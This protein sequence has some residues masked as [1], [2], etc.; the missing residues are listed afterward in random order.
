M[1]HYVKKMNNVVYMFDCVRLYVVSVYS[2][3]SESIITSLDFP[4]D[5]RL[6]FFLAPG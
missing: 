4:H 5:C 3:N 2:Y 1:M 6:R